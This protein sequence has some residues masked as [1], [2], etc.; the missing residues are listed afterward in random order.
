MNLLSYYI[1]PKISPATS[2]AIMVFL[3][4]LGAAIW[5][6]ELWPWSLAAI[7]INHLVLTVAALW[8]RSQMLGPNL[9]T[10]PE[11]S[12]RL[13][14][15]TLTIDDGPDPLV[16]PH[17]L[18]ILD[19][20]MRK[21]TFFCIGARAEQHPELCREIVRRGHTIENHTYHHSHFF[22]FFGPLRARHEIRLAQ[23][24]ISRLTRR[25]PQ[26]FRPPAGLRN[27]MLYPVVASL[28]LH[29]AAWT[30]RGYDTRETDP[31]KVLARLTRNLKAGDIL[32]LHDGNAAR[33][34]SGAPVILEVLPPLL[35]RLAQ[36]GLHAVPLT[37]E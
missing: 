18:D 21:A 4:A 2:V 6:P 22:S 9:V 17:V 16:T 5:Q 23:D 25:T 12:A 7:L 30:R 1:N 14:H 28:G 32:L 26:F 35:E 37:A 15:V 10:L 31:D 20:H 29:Q 34:R 27:P 24:A 33:T 19:N 36:A 3:A 8:P 11:R 13:N